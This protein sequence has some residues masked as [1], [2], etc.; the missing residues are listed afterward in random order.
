MP[1]IASLERW[2]EIAM[3][4]THT[5]T[6]TQSRY[7]EPFPFGGG[8]GGCLPARAQRGTSPRCHAV[9]R[10]NGHL[11]D[12]Y[13]PVLE[14]RP[15]TSWFAD[16]RPWS[17]G[18]HQAQQLDP[19]GLLASPLR[20]SVDRPIRVK[21]LDVGFSLDVG[22]GGRHDDHPIGEGGGFA[23]VEDSGCGFHRE[24]GFL[25]GHY[26]NPAAG[27]KHGDRIFQRS[28][29]NRTGCG[30]ECGANGSACGFSPA[31]IRTRRSMQGRNTDHRKLVRESVV[32]TICATRS[33]ESG[34]R[35]SDLGNHAGLP[36]LTFWGVVG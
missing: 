25:V 7:R 26:R 30:R 15:G 29:R 16:R 32:E 11:G 22:S 4:N 27:R 6:H 24:P 3:T 5:H 28:G 2:H 31:N 8:L 34:L 33:R 10:H 21:R 17:L 9:G 19:V 23:E 14:H 1:L 18:R 36:C 35:A 20:R 12:G 13:V